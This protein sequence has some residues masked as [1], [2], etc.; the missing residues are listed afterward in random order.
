MG[1]ILTFSPD[2]VDETQNT[3]QLKIVLDMNKP[4]YD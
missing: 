3:T 2:Q 1:N 4:V